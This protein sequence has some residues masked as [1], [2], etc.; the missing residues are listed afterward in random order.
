MMPKNDELTNSCADCIRKGCR[1]RKETPN[2]C[3]GRLT[4]EDADA[5]RADEAIKERKKI[6]DLLDRYPSEIRDTEDWN[7]GMQRPFTDNFRIIPDSIV[8]C[9]KLGQE[10]K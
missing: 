6:G 9:L 7:T 1:D 2:I 5:I 8:L 10:V 4:K 3:S